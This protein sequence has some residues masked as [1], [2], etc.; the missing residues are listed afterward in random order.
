[1]KK[2]G[3]LAFVFLA[4][5]TSFAFAEDNMKIL[6]RAYMDTLKKQYKTAISKITPLLDSYALNKVDEIVLAHQILAFSYCESGNQPKALEHLKALH[7]FSP[8]EDFR[9]FNPSES[10]ASLLNN[11]KDKSKSDTS[12]K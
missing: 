10:C 4:V 5:S 7:A 3:F 8:N 12:K 6:D 2:I 9:V 1:M 11:K